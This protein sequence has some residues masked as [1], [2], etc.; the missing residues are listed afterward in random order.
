MTD[1]DGWAWPMKTVDKKLGSIDEIMQ[2]KAIP[3]AVELVLPTGSW[4][5]IT[6]TIPSEGMDQLIDR[7]AT[8]RDA[9]ALMKSTK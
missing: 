5:N 4:G 7:L 8:A 9:A 6:L 1:D 2:I 3:G